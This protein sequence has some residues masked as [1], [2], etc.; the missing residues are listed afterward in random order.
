MK[1]NNPNTPN[2]KPISFRILP[3]GKNVPTSQNDSILD[4]LLRAGIPIHHSCGGMGT[5]GTCLVEVKEGLEE[6]GPRNEIELEMAQDKGFR[7]SERLCCQNSPHDALVIFRK[8]I[9]E[10]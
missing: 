8:P 10:S 6:L 5:C 7:D 3:D 9:T 2:K 1:T 4:S